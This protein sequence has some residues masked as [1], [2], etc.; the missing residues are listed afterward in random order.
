[1]LALALPAAVLWNGMY[2]SKPSSPFQVLGKRLRLLRER[3]KESV[4]EVSGAV[5][6]DID[7]LERIER[8]D[9]RPSEDV[10]EL[11]IDHF[12]LHDH[13]AAQLWDWAGYGSEDEAR[14]SRPAE[15]SRPAML[16]LAVDTRVMYS[17]GAQITDGPNGLVMTFTQD[18]A[19]GNGS[20]PV[21]VA[22]VGMSYE[23]AHAVLGAL[24][25]ALLHR[26]Y[27]N[28]PKA[29]PASSITRPAPTAQKPKRSRRTE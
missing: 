25:G 22:R 14:S 18:G 6:I 20:G 7:A 10:L 12:S 15:Q 17:D 3:Y 23:Q 2:D 9:E 21:P 1:M 13:E 24:Q 19:L 27:L 8:G 26:Q 29:L 11:L 5:E 4:A 28:G 16:L